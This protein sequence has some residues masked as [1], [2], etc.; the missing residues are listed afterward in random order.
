M[1]AEINPYWHD[2]HLRV[3]SVMDNGQAT[4]A[5]EVGDALLYIMKLHKFTETRWLTVGL[6]CRGLIASLSVGLPRLAELA[7]EQKV[8]FTPARAYRR[9]A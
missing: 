8:E 1:L 6:S 3:S 9:A 5:N 7:L 4:N 2:G